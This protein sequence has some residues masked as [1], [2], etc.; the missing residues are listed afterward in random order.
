MNAGNFNKS[1]INPDENLIHAMLWIKERKS[2][3]DLSQLG[4]F[5]LT[6]HIY[7]QVLINNPGIMHTIPIHKYI[8]LRYF[9]SWS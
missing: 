4:T 7:I 8:L 6:M 2:Y 1:T 3:N 9:E 5:F